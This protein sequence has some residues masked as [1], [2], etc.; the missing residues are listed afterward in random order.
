MVLIIVA[1]ATWLILVQNE[2]EESLK[3]NIVLPVTPL[4]ELTLPKQQSQKVRLLCASEL[5]PL[6]KS[7]L[8]DMFVSGR[9]NY[10]VILDDTT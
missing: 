3:A 7:V 8:L 10:F 6:I 1:S 5:I 2:G 9:L 4:R